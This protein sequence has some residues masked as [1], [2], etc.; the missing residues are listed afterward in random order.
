M[1]KLIVTLA[2]ALLLAAPPTAGAAERAYELVSPVDKGGTDIGGVEQ[3]YVSANGEV[4]VYSALSALP[5]ADPVA[6]G[7]FNFYRSVRGPEGWSAKQLGSPL[8]SV[9]N[10]NVATYDIFSTDLMT[11]VQWG[12][13]TPSPVP[14]ATEGV[15]NLFL[16]DASGFR[17]ITSGLTA[18]GSVQPL[19][20]SDDLSRVVFTSFGPPL[21]PEALPAFRLLYEWDVA[22]E[23]P[24]IVG[25]LPD[26]SPSDEAVDLAT[27][28][29]VSEMEAD[30]FNPISADGSRIF[31]F[32][33]AGATSPELYVRIDGAQTKRVSESQR[34]EPD[35]IEAGGPSFR[36]ASD[37]GSVVYF[38]SREKLTDDATT[39]PTD[40]GEDL[41]RFEVDS[42]ELTDVTV[43][44]VDP[45]GAEVEG[46]LGTSADGSRVYF[47]AAGAL[48]PGAVAGGNNLYLWTDDGSADGE[49]TFIA[50]DASDVNWRPNFF[51]PLGEH[52]GG[53]VT[54]DGLHLLFH[55]SEGLTGNSTGGHLQVYLYDAESGD[56]RC[57][58]CNPAGTPATA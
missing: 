55:S 31:F 37:D 53:R 39:G 11:G 3:P 44:T 43:D 8:G 6:N 13:A 30:S 35:P 5:G 50:P 36:V 27:P 57:V 24:K 23:A 2:A 26:G 10:I 19:G 49:I 1:R 46:V 18:E 34:A 16:D 58:S 40:A 52:V 32:T 20:G 41:Y 15:L 54:P 9:N 4:G 51:G 17:L 29:L 28:P 21:D 47:V 56:L 25:R 22:G 7:A 48:A 33:A 45:N 38:S 14:G 42:G 12:P